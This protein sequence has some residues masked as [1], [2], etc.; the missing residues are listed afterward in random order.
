MDSIT[1]FQIPT[2]IV[3]GIGAIQRIP[4]Y[5]TRRER[6]KVLLVTDQG[7]RQAGLLDRVAAVLGARGLP[8]VL[9]DQTEA[10][11]S[12]ETVDAVTALLCG[13]GCTAV[14]ALG[15]GSP[16]DVAKMAGVMATN[17]GL[18]RDYEGAGKI[19]IA[20]VPVIAVPTTAGTGS[21]VT[22]FIVITDR[23]RRYK[24]TVYSSHAIPAVAIVD[25]ALMT[26]MP[27]HVAAATGLDALTHGIESYVSLL[28]QPFSEA[29]SLHGIKLISANLRQVVANRNNLEAMSRLA[30]AST[31]VGTAFGCARLGNGHAMSHPLSG[32]YNLPHGVANAILLPHIMEYNAPACPEKMADISQAMGVDVVGLSPR[33]GAAAAAQAVRELMDDVGIP[34]H[35]GPLGLKEEDIPALTADAMK[36]GNVAANPRQTTPDDIMRLYR[37]AF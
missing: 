9:F 37:A 13:E 21:E 33:E 8:Y 32:Y 16:M 24:M 3:F 5:V 15:G 10:N 20:P 11:P 12:I 23:A 29:L 28:A 30:V 4:E 22:P 19:K 35:L 14:L 25:P 31:M 27:P 1:T 17:P 18:V 36:S 34:A 7:V 6:A 26:T 2:Q